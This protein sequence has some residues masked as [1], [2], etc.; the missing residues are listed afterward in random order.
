M[1]FYQMASVRFAAVAMLLLC[2]AARADIL[3]TFSDNGT[4][5]TAT[6]TGSVDL[7]ALGTPTASSS[8]QP[9]R[10]LWP[11]NGAFTNATSL[12]ERYNGTTFTSVT[13][14]GT[15][16]YAV[17]T[18]VGSSISGDTFSFY[19]SAGQLAVDSTYVSNSPLNGS[20]TLVGTISSLG[21]NPFTQYSF[22]R[23]IG[24]GTGVLQTITLQTV[25]AVPEPSA[26][27]LMGLGVA[28]LALSRRRKPA[29]KQA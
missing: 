9:T 2:S 4:L 3:I 29:S 20:M 18:G 1:K 10:V 13:G 19:A 11:I 27:V 12:I 5:T 22:S 25:S 7:G 6:I 26:F 15:G 28:G 24:G 16:G 8:F 17:T 23:S 21:I 14:Y